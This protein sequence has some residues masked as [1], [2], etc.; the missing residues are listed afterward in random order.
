MESE[1]AR[2][3]VIVVIK[4]MPKN[5]APGLDGFTIEFFLADWDIGNHMIE[6]ILELFSSENYSEINAT[7]ITLLPKYV[8]ILL[9]LQTSDLYPTIA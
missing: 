8:Y 7:L 4:S 2:N 6:S 1:V 9:R 3:E 5:K